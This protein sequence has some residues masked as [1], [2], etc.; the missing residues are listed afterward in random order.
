[1]R[2][3]LHCIPVQSVKYIKRAK[4]FDAEQ[5]RG[6]QESVGIL[7]VHIEMPVDAVRMLRE[8]DTPPEHKVARH[9]REEA[10]D[11]LD[12][13]VQCSACRVVGVEARG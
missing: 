12:T 1:M 7:C 6:G 9:G 2:D 13:V 11:V 10:Y 8:V 4:Q 3:F 5:C